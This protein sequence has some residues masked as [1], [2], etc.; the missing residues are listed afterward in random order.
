MNEKLTFVVWSGWLVVVVV[1]C[2]VFLRVGGKSH[3]RYVELYCVIMKG[4]NNDEKTE[5][6]KTKKRKQHKR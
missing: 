1:V 6:T 2:V 3:R 5:R 4:K